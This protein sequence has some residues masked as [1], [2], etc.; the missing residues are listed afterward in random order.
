MTQPPQNPQRRRSLLRLAALAA[1]PLFGWCRALW[2]AGRP[3]RAFQSEK[4]SETIKALA[5]DSEP[6]VTD[7]IAIGMAELAENGAVVPVKV[8]VDLADVR[9]ISI[10]ASR[11]PVPLLASFELGPTVR[12]FVAT[13]VKLAESCDVYAIARTVNGVYMARKPV[14]VTIGGCGSA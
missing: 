5:G 2:A 7:K 9:E 4:L 1:L 13:R 8:D 14:R 6:M 12:P 11:N 3:V 10:L